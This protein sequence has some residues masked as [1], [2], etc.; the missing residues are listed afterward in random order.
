MG[1]LDEASDLLESVKGK[2]L[3]MSERKRLAIE[4]AGLMLH[5]A[6]N[7]MTSS[8]KAI[9]EQLS[10]LM[11]DPVG[12]A[13]TTAMTD[14]CFRSQS[15]K[16]VA[17]QM[18]HLLNQLGV[19]QY[20]NRKEKLELTIFKTLGASISQFLVPL[21]MKALRKQTEKV[22]LPGEAELLTKHL[23]Q[24]K[25]EGVRQNINHLGEAIL[26]EAEA[27]KRLHTY[28]ED[29]K[30]P[31]IDYMSVKISTIYSQINLIA[32]EETI[33]AI[34]ERLKQ[35][36]RAA[37][38][39]EPHKFVNLDM[40]EYRDL[41]LTVSAFKKVL[42]EPEFHSYSAGIVLQAYLPDS[43][44]FQKDLTEWAKKKG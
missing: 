41:N 38:A 3:S 22:I 23:K 7:T 33:E 37:M 14:E 12:K 20:L 27:K 5:E 36:Y 25:A 4:L 15:N 44:P 8:E 26:S 30:N 9:Q 2:P 35:L 42:D 21:A 1:Y 24:R 34:G 32:Y 16:R 11:H 43:Y 17:D 19:P 28:L 39:Q 6:T 31:D 13:F 29:L 40:E 10:R 18:I